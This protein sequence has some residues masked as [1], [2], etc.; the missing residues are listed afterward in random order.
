MKT[1]S[2]LFALL[3]LLSCVTEGTDKDV[4]YLIQVFGKTYIC[5]SCTERWNL[6][7]CSNVLDGTEKLEKIHFPANYI[8][9]GDLI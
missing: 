9:V 7:E 3:F 6:R 4:D 5:E 8:E 1:Y 2:I